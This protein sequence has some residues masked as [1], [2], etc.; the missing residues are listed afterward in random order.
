MR[1]VEVTAHAFGPLVQE[2][3]SFAPGMTVICGDNES[4]KSSWHA[5]VQAALC[6]RRR[7]KGRPGKDDQRFADLHRPWDSPEWEVSCTISLADGRRIGLRHDL[8][9]LVDCR[10]T[11][12][13]LGRDVSAEVMSDGSPDGSRWLGLDRKSFA[14]TAS[15]TQAE[16][17]SV[18]ASAGDLQTHLQRAAANAST[19]STAAQALECLA[20]FHREHVGLDRSNSTRPLR[21][22]KD[23]HAIAQRKLDGAQRLHDEYLELFTRQQEYREE[24]RRLAEDL[25]VLERGAA[26]LDELTAAASRVAVQREK[27]DRLA[28]RLATLADDLDRDRRRLE[29]ARALDALLEGRAPDDT[30]VGE[31]TARLVAEALSAWKAA[32]E[33]VLLTGTTSAQ[34]EE[35]LSALPARPEGDLTVHEQVR[36]AVLAHETAQAVLAEH[37]KSKPAAPD[38]DAALTAAVAAGPVLLRELAQVLAVPLPE[39][40]AG[41]HGDLD[42]ARDIRDAKTE[43]LERAWERGRVAQSDLRDAESARAAAHG[44]AAAEQEA[45]A[46]ATAEASSAKRR[47]TAMGGAGAPALALGAVLLATGA[48][49]GG[50]VG[51]AVGV[52]LLVLAALAQTRLRRVAGVVALGVG[53]DLAATAERQWEA[54]ARR[55]AEADAETRRLDAELTEAQRAATVAEV[56]QEEHARTVGAVRADGEK[57]V[58]RCEELGLPTTVEQLSALA[59][60]ADRAAAAAQNETRWLGQCERLGSAVDEAEHRLRTA[61][62]ERG[63]KDPGRPVADLLTTYGQ[64]CR[65]RADQATAAGEAPALRRQLESRRQ[66]E[67]D[68]AR[69]E[70]LREAASTMLLDAATAAEITT[71]ADAD[72]SPESIVAALTQWQT[73]RTSALRTLKQQQSHWTELQTLLDGTT[74]DELALAVDNLMDERAGMEASATAARDQAQATEAELVS[75]AADAGIP[76][77]A[78]GRLG[79]LLDQER[80]ALDQARTAASE[81]AN[82]AAAAE[83]AVK[84]RARTLPSVAA[85]EEELA[86]VERELRRVEQLDRTITATQR[87]LGGAQDRVHRSIA[88]VLAAS[89]RQWLPRVTGGR[90][91]DAIVDP[92]NL[93]VQVLGDQ[94]MPRHSERLSRGTA[95]Q[96]Y[97]LLRIALTRHLTT[98]NESCPLLLDDVTVQSDA[99]RTLR[100]LELLHELSADQQV[101]L[102]AQE[103]LVADWA[104]TTLTG[105][106]DRV[107][108]LQPVHSQ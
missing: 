70:E 16:L 85:A 15:V 8:A 26:R 96:V 20:A 40:P 102:F 97:L 79:V 77:L 52:V 108:T 100:L 51:C 80:H 5:A 46:A 99:D 58:A 90:Y 11:D 103:R 35:A 60:E 48:T 24:A 9:G 23:R 39:A 47:R 44:R 21:R 82:R 84:D 66:R 105:P 13:D 4:A 73:E 29:R 104:H 74:V 83:G 101:I 12:L 64:D 95:E 94:R 31:N 2:S 43:A 91:L 34:L 107:I 14:A 25:Q 87:F 88:P 10:A 54:A 75:A 7:G 22:A 45:V 49:V 50:T 42:A 6:G 28:D 30:T 78:H 69:A 61:L 86:T 63:A 89:L 37:L 81:A 71:L 53:R 33:P 59:A 17:L 106:A 93:R 18:L 3:L 98:P 55:V 27:A 65:N 19:E 68:A 36:A 67:Q 32:P 41:L 57:A 72:A 62:S 56:R 38:A 92:E 76:D 1:M